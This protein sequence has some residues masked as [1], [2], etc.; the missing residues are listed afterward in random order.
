MYVRHL[1]LK[2]M[3]TDNVV[4]LEDESSSLL[5]EKNYKANHL[6]CWGL[7]ELKAACGIILAPQLKM[8]NFY[9]QTRRYGREWIANFVL[10]IFPLL[11]TPLICGSILKSPILVTSEKLNLT[12][13]HQGVLV[14]ALIVKLPS[15]IQK[16]PKRQMTQRHLHNLL[17]VL[18]SS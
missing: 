7:K 18:A 16:W 3:V 2:K 5:Q 17:V 1:I 8:R 14:P 15:L 10:K 6:N 12:R 11:E 9:S 4:M 13:V